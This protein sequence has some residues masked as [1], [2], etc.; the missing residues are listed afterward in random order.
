MLDSLEFFLLY[1]IHRVK[2]RGKMMTKEKALEKIEIIYKLN[3][4]FEHATKYISGLYGLTPDFWK[5]NFDFISSKM[6][7]KYPN[8]CY[9]GIV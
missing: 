2:K 6:L 7:A 8:L 3:G 1:L 5:E 4:D 9:G